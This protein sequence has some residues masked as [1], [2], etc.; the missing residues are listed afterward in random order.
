MKIIL[1]ILTL[2]ALGGCAVA[3]PAYVTR[4]VTYD[5]YQ[6]HEEPVYTAQPVYVQQPVYSVPVYAPAP[7]YYNPYYAPATFGLGFMFGNYYGGGRGYYGGWRG[8]HGR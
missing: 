6:W 4:Q 3:P 7:Y 1:P 8:Y 5:P 2:L